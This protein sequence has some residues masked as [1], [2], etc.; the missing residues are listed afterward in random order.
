LQLG[1]CPVPADAR[2]AGRRSRWALLLVLPFETG[3]GRSTLDWIGE[4]LSDVPNRRL[5]AADF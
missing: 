2:P 4:A 5:N 3:V 1:V